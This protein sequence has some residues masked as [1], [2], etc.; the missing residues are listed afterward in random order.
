MGIRSDKEI[1]QLVEERL[2]ESDRPLTCVELMDTLEI[3]KEAVSEFGGPDEDVR[4]AT[5]KLSDVLG[6]M[7]RRGL[8]IRYPAPADSRSMARYSYEWDKKLEKVTEPLSPP[9]R[10]SKM[11]VGVTEHADCIEIEFD[12][13]V[14]LIRPKQS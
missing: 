6:F 10:F 14:V 9:R 8:L 5:N 2:R 7:W 11:A 4:L 13:F 3:R 12:K 1:Y